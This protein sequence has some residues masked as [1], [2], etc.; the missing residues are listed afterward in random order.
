MAEFAANVDPIT[1]IIAA[2]P[3]V[4]PAEGF[5]YRGDASTFFVFVQ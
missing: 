4:R 1:A 3:T 5:H 2:G